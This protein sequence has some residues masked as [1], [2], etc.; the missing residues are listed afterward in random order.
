ML[1]FDRKMINNV[2]YIPLLF[3]FLPFLILNFKEDLRQFCLP[4]SVP[5]LLY[6]TRQEIGHILSRGNKIKIMPTI[7][8]E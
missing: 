2:Y 8:N 3:F 7:Q 6:S 1:T 4:F 5:D